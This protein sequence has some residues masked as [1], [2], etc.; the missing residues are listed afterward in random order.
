LGSKA[1][2]HLLLIY[3]ILGRSVWKRYTFV[4]FVSVVVNV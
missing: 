1:E 3:T 2:E 4:Y